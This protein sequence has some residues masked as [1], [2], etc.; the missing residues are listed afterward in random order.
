MPCAARVVDISCAPSA[1]YRTRGDIVTGSSGKLE[2]DRFLELRRSETG[3]G[4]LT[5]EAEFSAIEQQLHRVA[6]YNCGWDSYDA[7]APDPAT[8]EMTKRLLKHMRQS[9]FVPS[10]IVASVEGGIATYI[11]KG[12]KTAYIEYRNSGETVAAM[13]DRESHPIVMELDT[14]EGSALE[15]LNRIR[16]YLTT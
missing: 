1:F 3:S 12:G 15:A 6:S 5:T 11:F 7:E 13:Y 10:S 9:G 14:S 4:Y 16:E 2:V 8:V